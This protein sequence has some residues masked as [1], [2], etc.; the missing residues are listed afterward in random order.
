MEAQGE[1]CKQYVPGLHKWHYSDELNLL[2]G[3]GLSLENPETGIYSFSQYLAD[4]SYSNSRRWYIKKNANSWNCKEGNPFPVTCIFH[5]V[6]IALEQRKVERSGGTLFLAV[7][8]PGSIS[9]RK[10]LSD[11]WDQRVPTGAVWTHV[12]CGWV[13][14]LWCLPTFLLWRPICSIDRPLLLN[15]CS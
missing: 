2:Q 14:V 7:E 9:P 8:N 3:S 11:L 15:S 6:I 12:Y 5:L 13:S 1:Y 10:H 4:S